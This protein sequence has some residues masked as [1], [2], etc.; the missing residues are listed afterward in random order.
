MTL[1]QFLAAIQDTPDASHITIYLKGGIELHGSPLST[2]SKGSILS[3]I[4]ST[5]SK[6]KIT[7]KTHI[8]IDSIVAVTVSA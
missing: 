3:I 2:P 5:N 4:S 7:S 6:G 8:V 1:D